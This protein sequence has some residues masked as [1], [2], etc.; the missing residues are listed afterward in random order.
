M[1]WNSFDGYIGYL[2]ES[3][4]FAN[5]EALAARLK[6]AGYRYFVVDIGWYGEYQLVPGTTF[7]LHRH[8]DDVHLDA[9]GLPE[10]SRCYFPNGFAGLIA[11]CHALGVGF[12]LHINR[13]IFRKA[14]RLNLPIRNSRYRAADVS[15]GAPSCD[16][17]P[18]N[19]NLNPDH[20]GARDWY[21]ALVAKL[22]RWGV[23]FIKADDITGHPREVEL[24]ADAI[25]ACGR[26]IVLSLSSG[27]MADPA[28]IASYRRANML[29]IS[30]DIWDEPSHLDV[31]LDAWRRWQPLGGHGFW[32][33]LDMLPLGLLML[34]SRPPRHGEPPEANT[35]LEGVGYRRRC[36]LSED[37]QRAFMAMR[38]LAASPL[39]MGGDLPT[40]DDFTLRLITNA[41][42]I[43]CNQNGVV[44]RLVAADGFLQVWRTP[45][46]ER[47]E[48]GW[49]G[50]F[51]RD[52]QRPAS[53]TLAPSAAG[54]SAGVVFH[55]VWSGEPIPSGVR[56][57][58]AGGVLF[59]RYAPS[60][61]AAGKEARERCGTGI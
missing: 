18:Y 44:G 53:F 17:H 39:F 14:V 10:P 4:A 9:Y 27:G 20:P 58:A 7:P 50:V 25:A 40:L 37:Q 21:R 34:K 54:L 30:H 3:E 16:W 1:G 5:L 12:G 45:H 61:T 22:A 46:R 29:R 23:D 42:M 51:N 41:A 15:D 6:P 11:R 36:R 55:D 56:R 57:I 38:A 33:D 19:A 48:A 59:A 8:A 2:A 43:A 31:A 26:P 32:L 60:G 47:Q 52:D 49:L 24:L 28:H 13:G 35:L